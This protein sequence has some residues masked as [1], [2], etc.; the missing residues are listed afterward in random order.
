MKVKSFIIS[1][2][3]GTIT[4]YLLGGLFYGLL[5]PDIYPSEEQISP[6]FILFGCLCYA[7]FYT[8]LLINLTKVRSLKSGFTIG[9]ILG[10]INAACMNFF[11]YSSNPVKVDLFVTDVLIGTIST[12]I[13][14]AVIAITLSKTE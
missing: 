12:G 8:Y 1:I 3:T 4:Y 14:A 9:L 13:M 11:I 2:L 6:S 7:I 10:L 5:F